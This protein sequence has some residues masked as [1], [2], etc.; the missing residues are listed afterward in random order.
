MA[1]NDNNDDVWCQCFEEVLECLDALSGQ[2]TDID[3]QQRAQNLAI[4]CLEHGAHAPSSR[5]D[6]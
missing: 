2:I 4:N 3:Q 6:G 1:A 5:F